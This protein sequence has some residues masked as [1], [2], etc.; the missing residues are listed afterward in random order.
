MNIQLEDFNLSEEAFNTLQLHSFS[1]ESNLIALELYK[2]CTREQVIRQLQIYFPEKEIINIPVGA[3]RLSDFLYLEEKYNTVLVKKSELTIQVVSNVLQ[4]N[5]YT[6]LHLDLAN[7]NLEFVSVTPLNFKELKGEEVEYNA[8]ILFKRILI[9]AIKLGATDLHFNVKHVNM[10]PTYPIEYRRDGILCDMDLFILT[11]QLNKDIIFKLIEKK[12]DD[13]S[14]DLAQSSGV[15]TVASDI[16]N[17][18]KVELRVAANQVKNGYRCVIR[19]QEKTTISFKINE[20]GFDE[21]VQEAL[22][23]LAKKRSG[24]TLITGAIRTGKNTSAFAMANKMIEEPVSL[25][26]YDSPIE[27]LMAFPQVDYKEDP[28]RLLDCVRL[29]KKQDIDIAFLN[30][31]PTKDVAFGIKDL[32][33]SSIYVITTMHLDRIWHLPYR[34]FEYY[35]DSFKDIISQINGVVNQKMFGKLCPYCTEEVLVSSV[36]D[37]RK[38]DFLRHYNVNKI[39]APKGCEHCNDPVSGKFGYELGINQPYAEFLIFTNEIKQELLKCA[40]PY[41]MELIL[42]RYVEQNNNTLERYLSDAIR[43]G[44]LYIDALDTII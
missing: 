40:H 13:Y 23:L 24:L 1:D 34:L 30:E 22:D 18:G 36:E 20:L 31:I 43:D 32:V 2:F 21:T 28:K 3:E 10:E 16:F 8:D 27:V 42:K 12:T 26:S 7:Y 9:E 14:L 17:N 25:I 6:M 29:A 5:D 37:K 44:K 39:Y 33:N 11:K 15:V 41:E 38:Q 35:G 4:D 19:I